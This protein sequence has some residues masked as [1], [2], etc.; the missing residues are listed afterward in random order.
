MR[1]VTLCIAS[2]WALAAS[3][4]AVNGRTMG[5]F[6]KKLGGLK[7]T[8]GADAVWLR[9]KARVETKMVTRYKAGY[10]YTSTGLPTLRG[11]WNAALNTAQNPVPAAAPAAGASVWPL[12]NS[13]VPALVATQE[14]L[15][16]ART[17]VF[18]GQLPTQW[19]HWPAGAAGAQVFQPT[20]DDMA[21]AAFS[22]DGQTPD[23]SSALLPEKEY[24]A[25]AEDVQQLDLSGWG[26]RAQC[27]LMYYVL[28]QLA[29]FAGLHYTYVFGKKG[30]ENTQKIS[31]TTQGTDES[32][33][34][35][36]PNV[37]LQANLIAQSFQYSQGRVAR[38]VN[39]TV[40]VKDGVSV[41]GGL[42]YLLPGNIGLS[43][44]AG[45]R[46]Y[47]LSARY[48]DGDY[49]YPGTVQN[50]S[51]AFTQADNRYRLLIS[52]KGLSR[53]VKATHW[54]FVFG[55][56]IQV[57]FAS[58]HSV[59]IGADYASFEQTLKNDTSVLTLKNPYQNEP[60]A[61]DFAGGTNRGTHQF[62]ATDVVNSLETVVS[63]NDLHIS[64][65]YTLMC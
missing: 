52:K 31:L 63:V 22:Q 20:Y 50:L 27:T 64:A 15:N 46:H 56:A 51:T 62:V 14:I 44:Y 61:A 40:E 47:T 42:Q 45:V 60:S 21:K 54:T 12:A 53:E 6:S 8:L 57:L 43:A 10:L 59:S 9:K 55:G 19:V 29:L 37:T 49:A 16:A 25:K 30:Q 4:S 2:L 17:F 7:I 1:F 13:G 34:S 3:A 36:D 58:I 24:D 28:P 23:T 33:K 39:M 65:G 11:G 48:K 35:Q 26:V 5:L 38:D 18:T 32:I 41:F